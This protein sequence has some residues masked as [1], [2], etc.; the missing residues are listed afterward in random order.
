MSEKRGWRGHNIILL[1]LRQF[2]KQRKLCQITVMVAFTTLFGIGVALASGFYYFFHESELDLIKGSFKQ[3]VEFKPPACFIHDT[4]LIRYFKK[5]FRD[6]TGVYHLV[7]APHGSGKSTALQYA[8]DNN[9]VYVKID[10]SQDFGMLFAN[11]LSINLCCKEAKLEDRVQCSLNALKAAL[12]QMQKEGNPAPVL[13][14]DNVNFLVE[15]KKENILFMLQKFAKTMADERLLTVYL[16]SS[17]GKVYKTLTQKRESSRMVPHPHRQWELF[18]REAVNFLH[19]QCPLIPKDT[20]TKVVDIVGGHF[21]HLFQASS[22]LNDS[23]NTP[24]KIKQQL[25]SADVFERL[26]VLKKRA[27]PSKTGH[28][29]I[30]LA[31]SLARKIIAAPDNKIS[32]DDEL[33]QSLPDDEQ[34]VL[35]TAYLFDIDWMMRNITFQTTLVHSYFKEEIGREK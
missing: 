33:W 8:A 22:M 28:R 3:K 1:T 4:A 24:E 23:A 34:N 10:Y 14:I 13:I 27:P 15:Q 35:E 20:L 31:W 18:E 30:D 25:F 26:N 5:Q 17:Q 2:S 21:A 32:F 16:V 7:E 12:I 9:A 6:S 29:W 11:A 19:C